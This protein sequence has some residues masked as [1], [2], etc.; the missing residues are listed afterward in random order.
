ACLAPD[1]GAAHASLGVV[2]EAAGDATAAAR[3]F[4][5][6]RA[7]LARSK[8]AV[9][10]GDLAGSDRGALAALLTARLEAHR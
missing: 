2:L 7:A 3:A 9:P 4:M 1:H 5:A 6:A 8:G 10:E